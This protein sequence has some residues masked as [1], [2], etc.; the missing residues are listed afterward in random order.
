MQPSSPGAP[1]HELLARLNG[2]GYLLFRALIPREDVVGARSVIAG[3]LRRGGFVAGA[4]EGEGGDDD[5][6]GRLRIAP[7][8]DKEGAGP[9]LL[10]R[11]DL[12]NHPSVFSV[13]QHPNLRRLMTILLNPTPEP[14]PVPSADAASPSPPPPPPA[15]THPYKWLRAVP[16]LLHTGPHRDATYFPSSTYP[17]LLT[18]WVPLGDLA[19]ELGTLVCATPSAQASADAADSAIRLGAD[20]TRSGWITNEARLAGMEWVTESVRM[21]DVVVLGRERVHCSSVNMT[22]EWRVSCD[23]RWMRAEAEAEQEEEEVDTD[24]EEGEQESGESRSEDDESS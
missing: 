17:S 2:D 19:P 5:G 22:D 3:D 14:S 10:A 6:D 12:A 7:G 8:K 23:T 24:S 18:A 11:Q 13:L 20:G 9:N 16:T 4:R 1:A 21:G 15:L